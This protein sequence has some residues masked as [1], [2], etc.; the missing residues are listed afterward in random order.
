[1]GKI[2]VYGN[3]NKNSYPTNNNIAFNNNTLFNI[4][5]ITVTTN[6][7]PREVIN[8]NDK[9]H[10]DTQTLTL[11]SMNINTIEKSTEYSNFF[12][13]VILSFD[14]KNLG[15]YAYFG[16]LY[17]QIRSS[18]SEIITQ[19]KGSL[20]VNFFYQGGI[21]A[22]ATNYIYN[23][24]K[25]QSQFRINTFLIENKFGLNY[26]RNQGI[27]ALYDGIKDLT[28]NYK[29]YELYYV[30]N[31]GL[32]H[33]YPL[34]AFSGSTD[35]S[36]GY[37]N[38]IVQGH[39]FISGGTNVV[40]SLHIRPIE[41][42]YLKFYSQL[43]TLQ[44]YLLNKESTPK[45]TAV[46]K[47]LEED[48]DQNISFKDQELT[49]T[50]SDGYNIDV[51]TQQYGQ[52]LDSL[53]KI[54]ASYDKYKS[55]L[56]TRFLSPSSIIDLDNTEG[57]KMSKVLRLFGREFDEIKSFIDGITY[58]N[59]VSYDKV[60]NISDLLIKNL[61]QSLGWNAF[62]I[63]DEND[64]ID[65]LFSTEKAKENGVYNTPFEIDIELWRRIIIN[66][67]WF[68]KAKGTRKA[69]EVIF[70]FIGAPDCLI[71][72][73]E[74]IYLA[75]QKLNVNTIDSLVLK[76]YN[77]NFTRLP[78]DDDGFPKAPNE[79]VGF[80]FQIS[81]NTDSGQH[82]INLYRDLG[83]DVTKITDNRKSWIYQSGYTNRFDDLTQTSYVEND[84]RLII[85][86]KEVSINLDI[87]RAIE[88]DVYNF[89]YA[90]NYPVS[91]QG[92]AFPY[93]NKESTKIDVQSLTF[94][95]Y[96]QEVYSKFIDA[97]N[98]KVLNDNRGGG[99][100][101][102]TK[103]YTDYLNNSQADTGT[104]SNERSVRFM[105]E[106]INKFD[107]VWPKFIE[108]LIPATTIFEGGGEKY[109][110]TIFT[111]QKFVY[112]A[113]IDLGS[114]FNKHQ[115]GNIDDDI[116]II[117]L[118]SHVSVPT[119]G[120]L[121]IYKSDGGYNYSPGSTLPVTSESSISQIKRILNF[122]AVQKWDSSVCDFEQPT[123]TISGASK[124]INSSFTQDSIFYYDVDSSKHFD[125]IFNSSGTTEQSYTLNKFNKLTTSFEKNIIYEKSL[126]SYIPSGN[127]SIYHDDIP[128]TS[129]ERDSEY[130]I[131]VKFRKKCG[132][133]NDL[134]CLNLG[135]FLYPYETLYI[136]DFLTCYLMGN[137]NCD[138][139]GSPCS[140][141]S[142]I[143]FED[144]ERYMSAAT[145][146]NY[147]ENFDFNLYKTQY[148]NSSRFFDVNKYPGF[149]LSGN[150]INTA[151]EYNVV[152]YLPFKYYVADVDYYFVSVGSPS[153]PFNI[154]QDNNVN[155]NL[156]C[157]SQFI[158]ENILVTQGMSSFTTTFL[159]QG[160][161]QVAVRG[162]VRIPQDEYQ[163]D[164]TFLS[165][166]Q[167]RYTLTEALNSLDTLTV[168]YITNSTSP[169]SVY[170][171][172]SYKVS[173]I[174]S[175]TTFS[176]GQKF[177]F[178]NVTNKY[179]Y[180]LDSGVTSVNNV[181]ITVRGQVL[182]NNIDFTLSVIDGRKI[183]FNVD[184]F[185]SGDEIIACYFI[186]YIT[187]SVYNL[188]TN[189]FVF[190]WQISNS[191]PLNE[192]GRFY[193]EFTT[194]L[195]INFTSVLYSNTIPYI[196]GATNFNSTIDF[197]AASPLIPGGTYR[198]RILSEREYTTISNNVLSIKS[199][200]DDILVRLP[201]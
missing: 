14:R 22:T 140:T 113:G 47:V 77:P 183:I 10:V 132:D 118:A 1:M 177:H 160:D 66:T 179:E 58:V 13:R 44:K 20:Y 151:F 108:Q 173:S 196:I 5:D 102:L 163:L 137:A 185:I 97:K 81:G 89:N 76:N 146:Y 85:N 94:A 50:T 148:F 150:S 64:I 172:E 82:Y 24:G 117:K 90:H 18:I 32:E 105:L 106:Y 72:F 104:R 195:D 30:D 53:L 129:L 157:E 2:I 175:G 134:S 180:H 17:E 74:H 200:S 84:S 145:P 6:L 39:A 54:A 182:A 93:P 61:A 40:Q 73:N 136:L 42:E 130:L 99:Y 144:F 8:Y 69:I 34:L 169:N 135:D 191:I 158:T 126:V 142:G 178:N 75:D 43:N 201:S 159:P 33:Q 70:S 36:N 124:I 88:C 107:K 79:T 167:N 98:R 29:K 80:H 141:I 71:D 57:D 91:S 46:F 154:I 198:Y 161:I 143:T 184:G 166:L 190:N 60:E 31:A 122:W 49:W 162:L 41:S 187:E 119:L 133:V 109:R 86:T 7:A 147:Y 62:Q 48:Y 59:K 128:K 181:N 189:P 171:C 114:E 26:V 51:D 87:A 11:K 153:T 156:P 9:Y 197:S 4:N 174:T 55:D 65:S 27:N 112:Q 37:L 193:Q 149:I 3:Q 138:A 35:V 63:I 152:D 121:N 110:N 115:N 127:T 192:V 21:Y 165:P 28:T 103:L 67:N 186:Q 92:R 68:F 16:S 168:S 38:I 176:T 95:E 199:H 164:T 78:F 83:Y 139:P 19:W 56:I 131:K 188:P 96:I 12:N 111:P 194:P 25:N 101:T 170:K 23:A 120:S 52:Y 15:N 155:V 123:F 116:Q 45:Y 125:F 100:P